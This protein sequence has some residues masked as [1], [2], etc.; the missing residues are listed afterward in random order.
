MK[1]LLPLFLL[2]FI[3]SKAFSQDAESTIEYTKVHII[4]L[5]KKSYA[6]GSP[7][8]LQKAFGNVKAK[9]DADEVQGGYGYEYAYNGLIVDFHEHQWE[10]ASIKDGQY[11]V[12][13]NGKTYK[14]GDHI[15]KLK[16]MFSQSYQLRDLKYKRLRIAI[17]HK[18]QLTDAAIVI[19]YDNKGFIT[20]IWLGN[21]NS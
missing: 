21:N 4:S 5:S 13:L 1:I 17:A 2:L 12:V 11:S 15:S 16:A 6:L 3:S 7:L 20:E 8:A 10:A 9:R 19:D 18:K 14:V